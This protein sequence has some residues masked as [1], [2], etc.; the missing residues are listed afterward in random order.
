MPV[1]LCKFLDLECS[2]L[3]ATPESHSAFFKDQPQQPPLYEF[4]SDAFL[5]PIS[6]VE[7]NMLSSGALQN[8]EHISMVTFQI[9]VGL[10]D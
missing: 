4:L 9:V 10:R 6:W 3:P 2:L 7:A 8:F 5:P 1:Y